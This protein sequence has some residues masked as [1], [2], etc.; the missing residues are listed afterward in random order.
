V[1]TFNGRDVFNRFNEM[2]G[3]VADGTMLWHDAASETP[4]L[5][6]TEV[7]E[8][9]N[10][11]PV[12]H[13]IHIHLVDFQ[14]LDRQPFTFTSTPLPMTTHDGSTTTGATLQNVTKIGT[15]RGPDPHEQ[16]PKDTV[17]CY[18]NEVTRVVA[19][20][21]RPGNYVWHCHILHHED[22]DMMRPIIVA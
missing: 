2:L 19:K 3:T 14:V 18:P 16:G 17:T 8:I 4:A 6:S 1:I 15:A 11:G 22:H 13:P 20:F 12:A 5:G 7:W 10:T 21:D 9:H